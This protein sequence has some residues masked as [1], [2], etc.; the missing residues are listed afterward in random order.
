MHVGHGYAN[1]NMAFARV[2]IS[3]CICLPFYPES[4]SKKTSVAGM[5]SSILVLQFYAPLQKPTV[6][7]TNNLRDS[8]EFCSTRACVY[9]YAH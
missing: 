3:L 2:K 4:Y 8:D 7:V 6:L 5:Q 9:T 1:N